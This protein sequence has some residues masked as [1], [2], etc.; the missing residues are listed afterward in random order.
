MT[1]A[2]GFRA[3]GF[4][5]LHH[6]AANREAILAGDPEGVHQMRVASRRLRSA[7]SVFRDAL[8]GAWTGRLAREV[9]WLTGEMAPAREWDVF[10]AETLAPLR[11]TMPDEPALA[12]LAARGAEARE[13]A[14]ERVRAAAEDPRYTRLLL[15]LSRALAEGWEATADRSLDRSRTRTSRSFSACRVAADGASGR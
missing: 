10:L 5:C 11:K 3:I 2:D 15:D 8:P 14:Y 1:A 6:L 7:I 12:L 4:S 9:R 13:R